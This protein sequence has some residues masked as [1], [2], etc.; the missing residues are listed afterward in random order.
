MRQ[1]GG[2]ANETI[3]LDDTGP[4]GWI[5]TNRI[6]LALIGTAFLAA[7]VSL[8]ASFSAPD[9]GAA[10]V[11]DK[12][13]SSNAQR[14]VDSLRPG[15]TGCLRGGV[16]TEGDKV[17]LLKDGGTSDKKRIVV[18]NYPGEKATIRAQVKV[19]PGAD[20]VT[21]RS[22]PGKL[23][24]LVLDGTGGPV[25]AKPTNQGRV[26]TDASPT[27][28]ADHTN[29]IGLDIT[30]RNR[31]LSSSKLYKTGVCVLLNDGPAGTV[32]KKNRI[33]GCGVKQGQ[34]DESFIPNFFGPGKD[35]DNRRSGSPDNH[36]MYISDV[37]GSTI[38]GDNL[39][40]DNGERGVQLYPNARGVLVEGNVMDGNSENLIM[41]ENSS[42]NTV[43]NNV[44]SNP[45]DWNVNLGPKLSGSG[46]RVSNNC[47]WSSGG[48]RFNN[49][50]RNTSVLG[51]V[52]AN[53][54][55]Q[56]GFKITNRACLAKYSGTQAR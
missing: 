30:K 20:Y 31:E 25:S 14:L 37:S 54:R 22:A 33:H 23:H 13:T 29:W 10:S 24:Q 35:L 4:K 19:N 26:N 2:P 51:N 40:Y 45:K 42:Q 38:I 7:L 16:Y 52:T 47:F 36:G 56:K 49:G 50:G 5:E 8:L 12:T 27:I 17:L 28:S 39:I 15:Q 53:P 41:N 21:F 34:H 32:M 55:Y 6:R 11:C 9:A 44:F 3:T 48:A 1:H 43:R 46:N 18:Q